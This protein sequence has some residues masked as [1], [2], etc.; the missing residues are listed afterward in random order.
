[1]SSDN[2]HNVEIIRSNKGGFK[3]IHMGYMYTVHKRR[4]GGGIRWRCSQRSLHCKGSISTGAHPPQ[5]NMTHNHSPDPHSV[6]LARSRQAEDQTF[7]DIHENNE[8]LT[9]VLPQQPS[10]I[11]QKNESLLENGLNHSVFTTNAP[12]VSVP[13]P[14]AEVCLRWNSHHANIKATFPAMLKRKQ[15]VDCTVSADGGKIKCHKLVLSSCSAYFDDILNQISPGEHPV[16]FLK[17]VPFWTVKALIDFMYQGEIH[18]EQSRLKD[19]LEAA[20][21]LKVKGLTGSNETPSNTKSK[22]TRPENDPIDSEIEDQID[23]MQLLQNSYAEPSVESNQI[24]KEEPRKEKRILERKVRLN[25]NSSIG[26]QNKFS[27]KNKAISH[28]FTTRKGTK[29]RPVVKAPKYYH[30]ED[31]DENNSVNVNCEENVFNIKPEPIEYDSEKDETIDT[32][33]RRRKS[34]DVE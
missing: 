16:V 20:E 5:V 4:Q 7:A 14:V 1:M 18:I 29:S 9:P 34:N 13:T 6:M 31:Y 27:D 25:S 10:L 28:C 33:N 24:T 3:L 15:Y 8:G 30:N 21:V 19:V 2:G 11:N 23:P 32:N 12:S 17:G 22:S 26:S